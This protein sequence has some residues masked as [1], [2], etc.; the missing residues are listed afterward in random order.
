MKKTCRRVLHSTGLYRRAHILQVRGAA[1]QI[2][3]IV[4]MEYSISPVV[5]A[6][7]ADDD[8]LCAGASTDAAEVCPS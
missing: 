1:I 3:Q 4:I 6:G 5:Q 8:H 7:D 2:S